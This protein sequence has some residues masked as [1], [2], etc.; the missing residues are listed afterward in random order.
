MHESLCL[1]VNGGHSRSQKVRLSF[2]L[3]AGRMAPQSYLIYN[4]YKVYI[5][6]VYS[7]ID[8]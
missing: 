5:M 1:E 6:C 4:N 3:N 2:K 7:Y 8:D